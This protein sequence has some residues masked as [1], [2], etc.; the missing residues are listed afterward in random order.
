MS[1][2][3]NL[4]NFK[5]KSL[6]KDSDVN[7]LNDQKFCLVVNSALS[8]LYRL[9]PKN[10]ITFLANYLLN[11]HRAE[12]IKTEQKVVNEIKIES[13]YKLNEK[14]KE[15]QEIKHK[16]EEEFKFHE[17]KKMSLL[18][19]IKN[20]EDVFKILGEISDKL[21][22]IVN[23]T[24]VSF[25]LYEKK[26]RFVNEK[27]DENAHLLENDVIRYISYDKD[28][29]DLLKHKCLEK[30]EGVTYDLFKNADDDDDGGNNMNN[31]MDEIPKEEPLIKSV[32]IE[33]VIRNNKIKFFKEPR[34]GCY[35]AL[36]LTYKSSLFLKSLESSILNWNNFLRD[37]Q[38]IEQLKLQREMEKKNDIQN[39]MDQGDNN[40]V[41]DEEDIPEAKLAD[42]V[43]ED[44]K[45]ILSLDTL[46][47]DRIFTKEEN[48]FIFELGLTVKNTL[49]SLEKKLLLK[50][51]DLKIES[52]DREFK[53]FEEF[54]DEK[55][56]EMEEK[57]HKEYLFKLYEDNIPKDDVLKK[58]DLMVSK[59]QFILEE[60]LVKESFHQIDILSFS[61]YDVRL[62]FIVCSI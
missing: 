19:S 32:F 47:Q 59:Y 50:D 3:S 9:Q 13:I 6:H 62:F 20:S 45:L 43:T 15:F 60:M 31:N 42:F 34:L 23:A 49:E 51:R 7:F 1:I 25:L 57:F 55:I 16:K 18:N 12:E 39:S 61:K 30:G 2:V 27:E 44:K 53:Y 24:G 58:R 29:T 52:R 17:N 40:N 56:K 8:E 26:R 37:Q 46:G 36:N 35:L 14:T 48:D 22:E 54:K 38:E 33:E 41:M 5:L 11:E 4:E 10:P 28:H 21:K